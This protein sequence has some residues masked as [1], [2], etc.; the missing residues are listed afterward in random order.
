RSRVCRRVGDCRSDDTDCLASE[1]DKT[2]KTGHLDLMT[3]RIPGRASPSSHE[4]LHVHC[5][6][7]LQGT[8]SMIALVW[9]ACLFTDCDWR[10]RS[11][12]Q[13][14]PTGAEIG[15]CDYS[16]LRPGGGPGDLGDP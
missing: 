13:I 10:I 15:R 12:G 3:D 4:H 2:R 14:G 16:A 6:L 1:L 11:C 7:L 5:L 8:T 9:C